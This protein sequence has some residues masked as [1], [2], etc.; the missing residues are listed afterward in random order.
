MV[1]EGPNVKQR[2]ATITCRHRYTSDNLL[3]I[4]FDD[5]GPRRRQRGRQTW[6]FGRANVATQLNRTPRQRTDKRRPILDKSSQKIFRIRKKSLHQPLQQICKLWTRAQFTFDQTPLW[7]KRRKYFW[8]TLQKVFLLWH[9][10]PTDFLCNV[11]DPG[12]D[13]VKIARNQRTRSVAQVTKCHLQPFSNLN[14]IHSG[15][16]SW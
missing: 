14:K 13:G 1:S 10:S 12:D 15:K 8:K 2:R 5:W 9:F 16:Q 7:T 3:S 11:E 6:Q 4:F